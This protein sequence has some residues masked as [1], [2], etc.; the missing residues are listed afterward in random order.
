[1]YST[2]C[3]PPSILHRVYS[4]KYTPLSKL[5]RVHSTEY[6]PPNK[7]LS[8]ACVFHVS[9]QNKRPRAIIS[10]RPSFVPERPSYS[11]CPSNRQ[12]DR[13]RATVS[14]HSRAMIPERPSRGYRLRATVPPEAAV[15]GLKEAASVLEDRTG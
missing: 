7:C 15:M 13:L 1:M 5:Y 2:K 8:Y 6:T 12:S 14:H 11:N 4:A 3:I 9:S 10:K